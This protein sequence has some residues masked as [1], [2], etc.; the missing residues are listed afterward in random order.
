MLAAG[1]LPHQI[2]DPLQ[3]NV[4]KVRAVLDHRGLIYTGIFEKQQLLSL[5]RA[6]G[7]LYNVQ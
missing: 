4:R 3:L 7:K 1:V 5:L 6:S 2:L